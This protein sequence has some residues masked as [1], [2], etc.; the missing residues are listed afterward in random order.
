MVR[1]ADCAK[2]SGRRKQERKMDAGGIGWALP[3][4]GILLLA[5]VLLWAMMRN[6]HSPP[7]E[8]DRTESATRDLYREEE[9]E[10]KRTDD[11]VP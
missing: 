1:Q 8:R 5:A 10:R 4:V 6:R 2:Q 11:D 3:V 9:A 7:S